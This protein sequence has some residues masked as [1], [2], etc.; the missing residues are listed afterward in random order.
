MILRVL[1]GAA[2]LAIIGFVGFAAW[3]RYEASRLAE[4]R[5]S[6]LSF[7]ELQYGAANSARREGRDPA[8]HVREGMVRCEAAGIR[9][10]R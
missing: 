8:Q 2:C 5:E 3:D 7:C 10:G 9:E 1:I 4:E 6:F